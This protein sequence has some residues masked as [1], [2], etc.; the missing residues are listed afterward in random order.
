M[1]GAMF[2]ATDAQL[3]VIDSFVA[4]TAEENCPVVELDVAGARGIV[5]VL[6]ADAFKSVALEPKSTD[7]DVHT[8]HRGFLRGMG[9][10]GGNIITKAEVTGLSR[11]DDFWRVEMPVG[12][13]EALDDD[14]VRSAE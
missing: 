2:V 3:P 10:R 11:Q 1:R 6:R 5:P 4:V 9:L 14:L 8:L 7:I 12:E 13:F